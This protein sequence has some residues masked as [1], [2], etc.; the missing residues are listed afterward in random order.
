MKLW[1]KASGLA[2]WADGSHPYE[3]G[4]NDMSNYGRLTLF[5]VPGMVYARVLE[6][7]RCRKN[8]VIFI[9]VVENWTSFLSS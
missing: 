6:R 4:L 3:G 2:D 8:N 5:S 1:D 9:L 7:R